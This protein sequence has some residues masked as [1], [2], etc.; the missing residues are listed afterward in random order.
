MI[1]DYRLTNQILHKIGIR[2]SNSKFITHGVYDTS[3]R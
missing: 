2:Q 3:T 1:A